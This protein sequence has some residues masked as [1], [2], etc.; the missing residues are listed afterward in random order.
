MLFLFFIPFINYSQ[1]NLCSTADPF[2]TGTT[3]NYP[4]GVNAGSGQSG[5]SY[6]CLGSE[7]NPAWYYLQI[8][9]PGNLEIQM[10]GGNSSND[11]DFCCWGPF[12]NLASACTNLTGGTGLSSH[13]AH[14]AGGGYPSGNVVDCSYDISSA[15]WCYI[16][17]AQTGQIY[18]LMITNYSNSACNIIFSQDTGPGT[19]DCSIV[20]PPIINNGP[21]CVG[22]TLILTVTNPTNG[23]TY[24]WTGPNGFTSTTM[25]P[26]I[27]NVTTANAGV[28]SLSITLNGLT[29]PA[30]TTTVV[31]NSNPVVDAGLPQTICAGA[32][33]SLSASGGTTYQWSTPPGGTTQSVSVT[34]ASTS[35]YT[36]TGTTNG[37]TGTDNVVVTVNP[38]PTLQLSSTNA[39]CGNSNGTATVTATGGSGSYTYS[40]NS[41]PVQTTQTATNLAPGNYIVTVNDGNCP[42]IGTVT[43]GNNP[44]PTL[45]ISNTPGTCGN[46]NGTATV[47]ATGGSGNFI[48]SWST[49][50]TQTTSS[51]SALAAGTYSV[52]VSDGFCTVSTSTN[53]V[54]N[55]APTSSISN[56]VNPTCGSS[57]G[58]V[59]VTAA[60]G[61]GTY[62]YTW[63]TSPVQNTATASNL[64]Q[65]TY[66]VTV[67]DGGCT[68]TSSATITNIGGPTTTTTS[69]N[70]GCGNNTGTATANPSGGSGTYTYTWDSS[71]AQSTQTASNLAPGNY[72]VT[73]ND[74]TCTVVG[75][76][77]VG[78]DLAP[79]LSTTFTNEN[80]GH[81]NGTAT[82]TA[83]GGTGNYTYNWSI[84][85]AQTTQTA[86]NLPGGNYTVT[87]NDGICTVTTT[88]TITN[89]AG[90][91]ASISNP[92][93]T[94]CSL[95]NGSAV[96]TANGGTPGYTYLWNSIPQQTTTTLQGVPA[97]TYSVTVTDNVGCI[98]TNTVT[99]TDSPGPTAQITNVSSATCGQTD[100]SISVTATGGTSPITYSWNTM[101]VQ[102]TPTAVGVPSG[103]Y[104]VTV[105]D[106]NGCTAT[107]TSTV[108]TTNN[109]TATVIT[110]PDYC[111]QS[112]GTATVSAV[113]GSGNYTYLW[114]NGQTT[115]TITG[116]D[117][118]SVSVTVTDGPCSA[119]A[120][121][122]VT[123]VA[124]PVANFSCNPKIL[125]LM[126]GPVSFLDNSTGN[127]VNWFWIYGD[128]SPD[129]TGSANTHVFQNL[130]TF[131][132]TLIITDDHGCTDTITDTIR[133]K[134]IFT[135]YVPNAFT[136]NGDGIN[137]F[138]YP[139]GVSVDPDNFDEYIFDR[140]GNIIF[141]TNKWIDNRAEGWNGTKDNDGSASD[142]VPDVFVYRIKVKEKAGPKHE[143]FGRISSIP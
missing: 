106:G 10:V 34:P 45:S 25:N 64:T 70:A 83:T 104:I 27:P 12:P 78:N 71:P 107:A 6:S 44:S 80:C 98:A 121:G 28:Y 63:S 133:V 16:P 93:N 17:N 119:T 95:S 1:N 111:N 82:V 53:V 32:V 112:N 55:T 87:V 21:L 97:G 7:P 126:E 30:V 131:V 99:I 59:T 143:Y 51:I 94:T 96:V 90:P 3:Y 36:V 43:V 5:P 67:S 100:G 125:N 110:T 47:V 136:P 127:V 91:S 88:V 56:S 76:V 124:G 142:V 81:A 26:T 46:F 105:S 60:A 68:C 139:Q 41:S 141:H 137:D 115:Q 40:W 11:I 31:I 123:S 48:Y 128:G 61:S 92:V 74:G 85:P 54:V 114:S 37:C 22:Q 4:A 35:T 66:T 103:N 15:E 62:T 42:V 138:F 89:L 116:L 118:G 23:A 69:T 117:V 9:N 79:T 20:A 18:M 113:G 135:F 13:H 140:W 130:G 58:S 86:T 73:V 39:S 109:P 84:V 120:N 2:C 8:A 108:N 14:G 134:D 75:T 49:T 29:S 129:G 52:T 77:T 19:T 101:P 65:G 122:N 50:P 57:N 102:S 38:V 72:S 24:H 33:A 132:V